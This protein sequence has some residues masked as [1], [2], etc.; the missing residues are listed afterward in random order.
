MAR[1]GMG[2]RTMAEVVVVKGHRPGERGQ[3][4]FTLVSIMVS[5]TTTRL[6]S[7]RLWPN[8]LILIFFILIHRPLLIPNQQ[9]CPSHQSPVDSGRGCGPTFPSPL[10][11]V[12]LLVTLTG[13]S[14]FRPTFNCRKLIHSEQQ[15]WIP[16]QARYAH[17]TNI[18][19]HAR[20]CTDTFALY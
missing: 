5:T 17:E 13:K 15:V 12:S 8:S 4:L 18:I 6:D 2:C 16:P 3:G 7:S 1:L 10:V 9:K 11:W 14:C 19:H 20:R